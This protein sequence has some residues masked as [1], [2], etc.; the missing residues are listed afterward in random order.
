VRHDRLGA[1]GRRSGERDQCQCNNETGTA[2]RAWPPGIRESCHRD[3]VVASSQSL[4]LAENL[5]TEASRKAI[6]KAIVRAR[7]WYEQ[8]TPGEAE[9]IAQLASMH[10]LTPRFINLHLKLIPLSPEW[11]EKMMANPNAMPLSLDDLLLSIPMNWSEQRFG[12]ASR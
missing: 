8:L 7:R 1:S 3:R 5:I 9:S 11:I 2:Q 12:A 6:L 4:Q 10:S